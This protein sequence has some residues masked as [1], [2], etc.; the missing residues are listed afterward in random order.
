VAMIVLM[1]CRNILKKCDFKENPISIKGSKLRH[2]DADGLHLPFVQAN[3]VNLKHAALM[4]A[5]LENAQLEMSD[6][7]LYKN[8]PELN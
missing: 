7:A 6:F 1:N 3:G 8:Y 4:G 2:L 5:N